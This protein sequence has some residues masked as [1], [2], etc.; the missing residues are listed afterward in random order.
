MSNSGDSRESDTPAFLCSG[1]SPLSQGHGSQVLPLERSLVSQRNLF[2]RLHCCGHPQG[3]CPRGL[4]QLFLSCQAEELAH[5]FT[6]S[7]I[8]LTRWIGSSPMME[9]NRFQEPRS[10]ASDLSPLHCARIPY[11]FSCLTDTSR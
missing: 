11:C 2:P 4:M 9:F 6:S 10:L 3:I 8:F 5:S 1:A 7:L